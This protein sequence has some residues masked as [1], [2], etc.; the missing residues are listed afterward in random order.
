MKKTIIYLNNTTKGRDLYELLLGTLEPL[1]L[2]D[3][4]AYHHAHAS[5]THRSQ[6]E[7]GLRAGTVRWVIATGAL[8]MGAD[9]RDIMRVIQVRSG[10]STI[11]VQRV[12]K[13]T[14]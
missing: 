6:V 9:I 13:R 2:G 8:G 14:N 3:A 12:D 11:I 1:G 5:K 7:E 4:V 10:E